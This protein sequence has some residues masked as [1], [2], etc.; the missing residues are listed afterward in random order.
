MVQRGRRSRF[1]PQT[2]ERGRVA[3]ERFGQELQR[4]F[5]LE[6]GILGEE[7]FA[8]AA[9]SNGLDHA[10]VGEGSADHV[11]RILS[12]CAQLAAAPPHTVLR[13][14]YLWYNLKGCHSIRIND[15]WRVV[16][17]W[18]DAGAEEVDIRDYH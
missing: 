4:I 10:V 9:F 15:P 12:H 2:R 8:H 11:P 1:P 16:F 7:D 18:T 13:Y 14:T 3:L 17:R 6:L 5:P